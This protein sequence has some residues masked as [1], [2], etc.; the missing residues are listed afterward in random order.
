MNIIIFVSAATNTPRYKTTADIFL[1]RS[2]SS[3]SSTKIVINVNFTTAAHNWSVE[4]INP[5]GQSSGQFNFQI[6]AQ[7]GQALS[8]S[9][10]S[11]NHVTGMNSS[12]PFT[13][14]GSNFVSVANVTL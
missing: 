14:N 9:S 1:N 3:F 7:H 6:I 13:I 10:V 2:A 12:Q 11:P 4:V 8:M 5:D